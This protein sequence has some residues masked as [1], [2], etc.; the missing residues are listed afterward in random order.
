[1][2]SF[3]QIDEDILQE[4]VKMGFD[5]KHLVESLYNRIQNEVFLQTKS[6]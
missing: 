6:S 1:M 4:V 2:W 5:K 3:L